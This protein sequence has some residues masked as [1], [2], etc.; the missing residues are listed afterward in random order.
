MGKTLGYGEITVANMTEPF[1][2]M[3]TNE[4]QQFA[5]DS[6]RKVTSA[7]S[8][9]TDIIV[10]RGS[11]ERTDYTIGNITSGSGITVSKSSKRITFS[12]SA[13]TT[14]GAD[15]GVIEI[16]ITLDGQ[17]VKKQFSWSCGKQGPQGVKGQDGTSVKITSKSVTY[18]TSTSG[19]TAPIGTWSTAVPTVNNGQY[20]WTKITVQ[21]SDG[22]KTEAYSVS[23]K[24]TNGTN[25]TSV[26]VSKT[27]VTYQV[28]T[29]G[30]TAPTGAWS[31][32]MPT[33]DQGQYLWTKTYVKYSDG[34]E[35]T[36]YSVS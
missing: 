15:T 36:S 21:Y 35:T 22:N 29:S 32:T 26:T 18:Q 8:Y 11:Q 16:P 19:T 13:G 2:V 6:N 23:Y 27:E 25:G 24:G 28:S 14:I 33:C 12:V 5:T 20:L 10:V 31:T 1:T 30:T 4:A 3:L 9:Y 34:K 17:T 7:Q